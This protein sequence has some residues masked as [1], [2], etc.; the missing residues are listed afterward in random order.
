MA[1]A[2]LRNRRKSTIVHIMVMVVLSVDPAG[3]GIFNKGLGV[4]CLHLDFC[5]VK[6]EHSPG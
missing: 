5:N 3:R 2:S 1:F 4:H 6:G